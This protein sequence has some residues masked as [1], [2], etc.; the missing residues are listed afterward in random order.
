MAE[1]IAAEVLEEHPPVQAV[2][3]KVS[4]P[5]VRLQDTVLAGSAVEILRRRE[6]LEGPA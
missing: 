4:K 5:N 1:R 6:D 2:R 3:V